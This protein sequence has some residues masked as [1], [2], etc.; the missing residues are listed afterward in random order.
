MKYVLKCILG[1]SLAVAAQLSAALPMWK[2]YYQGMVAEHNICA[3]MKWRCAIAFVTPHFT[4]AGGVRF[5][6]T[7]PILFSYANNLAVTSAVFKS[8]TASL[9]QYTKPGGSLRSMVNYDFLDYSLIFFPG[10]YIVPFGGNPPISFG[11]AVGHYNAKHK[12]IVGV[13]VRQAMDRSFVN[14]KIYFTL[15]PHYLNLKKSDFN[16]V[17]M[18]ALYA[19]LT[20]CDDRHLGCAISIANGDGN[21]VAYLKNDLAMSYTTFSAALKSIGASES[22]DS[23]YSPSEKLGGQ[24]KQSSYSLPFQI[25]HILPGGV[26]LKLGRLLVGGLGMS[27]NLVPG[28][29]AKN[30]KLNKQAN[31]YVYHFFMKHYTPLPCEVFVL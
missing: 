19:G 31:A 12:A 9:Y 7:N 25:I 14:Q 5:K 24:Y 16:L 21:V 17:A 29:L 20:W 8:D 6:G 28:G 11:V 15:N 27:L 2:I 18:H 3:K 23:V 30:I 4:R 10:G 13:K 22:A 26:P 1:I